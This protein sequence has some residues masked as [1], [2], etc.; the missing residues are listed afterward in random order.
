MF[1]RI[2]AFDVER[3]PVASDNNNDGQTDSGFGSRH[4][5]DKENKNLPLQLSKRAAE[6]YK[7]KIDG[8]EHQF[9]GHEDGND[10]ALENKRHHA[11]S[12][13]DSTQQQII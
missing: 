12:E 1:E 3:S 11:Q 4:D 8:V 7:R 9:N 6:R 5:N 2:H 13:Q 10:V